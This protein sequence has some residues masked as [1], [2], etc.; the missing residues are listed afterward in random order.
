[1][2]NPASINRFLFFKIPAAFFCGVR[3]QNITAQNCQVAVTHRW[4]NQNPFKSMYFAVQAM[5][6]ELTTGA[7]VMYHIQQSGINSSMLVV[8]NSSKFFKKATGRICFTCANGDLVREVIAAAIASN[9]PQTC[10]LESKGVDAS[11]VI[12]AIMQFEW[13]IKIR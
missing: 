5:A 10:M 12:V 11:G 8:S 2:Q 9:N 1:M 6:A 7:L 4:F 3:V 13:S